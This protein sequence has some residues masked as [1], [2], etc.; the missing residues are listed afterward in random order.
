MMIW[1]LEIVITYYIL[2]DNRYE[3]HFMFV[4]IVWVP[5]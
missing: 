5:I 1:K 4:K 2:I 3:M